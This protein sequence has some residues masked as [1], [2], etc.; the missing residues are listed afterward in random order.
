[1]RLVLSAIYGALAL[2]VI[3]RR[4]AHLPALARETFAGF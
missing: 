4:R 3:V 1:V 2:F